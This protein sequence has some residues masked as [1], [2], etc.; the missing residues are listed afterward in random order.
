VSKKRNRKTTANARRRARARRIGKAI[1]VA[2]LDYEACALA[3]EM[4]PRSFTWT[5]PDE[6]L[7]EVERTAARYAKSRYRPVYVFIDPDRYV[8]WCKE[9]GHPVDSANSRAAYA[10][11]R[12]DAGIRYNPRQRLWPLSVLSMVLGSEVWLDDVDGVTGIERCEAMIEVRSQLMD[13]MLAADGT[14]RIVATAVRRHDCGEALLW[15]YFRD[16]ITSP[17]ELTHCGDCLSII[18]TMQ[19]EQ[20][21]LTVA[22]YGNIAPLDA[23]MLLATSCH[24]LV[25]IDARNGDEFTFR[26]FEIDRDGLR[27]VPVDMLGKRLGAPGAASLRCGFER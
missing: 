22:D 26:A 16:A 25:G 13:F 27:P 10:G 3:P 5:D 21:T 6:Y 17:V 4:F 24:G 2:V 15:Q 18:D 14:Y 19:L 23:V 20:N 9:T 11:L 8:E 1:A 12:A 7:A